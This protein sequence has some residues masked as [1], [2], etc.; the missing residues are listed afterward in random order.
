M[1]HRQPRWLF[2][3]APRKCKLKFFSAW[4]KSEGV[5]GTHR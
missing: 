4:K 1:G 3:Q 5:S 2:R